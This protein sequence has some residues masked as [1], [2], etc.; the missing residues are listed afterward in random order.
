MHAYIEFLQFLVFVFCVSVK[1][2]LTVPLLV[3]VCILPEK[4]VPE[5]TCTVSGGTLNTTHS[6][7]HTARFFSVHTEQHHQWRR[8]PRARVNCC[9]PAGDA[10]LGN[11][12]RKGWSE[13]W[14]GDF[15]PSPEKFVKF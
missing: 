10:E 15:A 5:M 6:L 4:A 13:A 8:G 11:R 1:V 9:L 3:F 12:G 14:G 2:K 7:T